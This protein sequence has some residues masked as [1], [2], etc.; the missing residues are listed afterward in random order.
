MSKNDNNSTPLTTLLGDKLLKYDGEEIATASLSLSTKKQ[1]LLYFSAHWCPPCKAFTPIISEAYKGYKEKVGE[2]AEVEI[3]F[4]SRDSDAKTFAQYHKEMSFLAIPFD[5][6]RTGLATKFEIDGIP[7]LIAINQKGEKIFEDVDIRSLI[8]THG[9]ATFP[10]TPERISELKVAENESAV[11]SLRRLYDGEI[12]F[13]IVAKNAAIGRTLKD[14]MLEN[15]YIALVLGDG[16]ASDDRYDNLMEIMEKVNSKAT[17]RCAVI[18]L[19]WST[20]N[21]D[22]DHQKVSEKY[23]FALNEIPT[24]AKE[25]IN[26]IVGNE[27]ADAQT[28][29]ILRRGTGLCMLNGKCEDED[30]PI[31]V[32]VDP[33]L[34]KIQ[35]SSAD[36]FPWDE[37]SMKVYEEKKKLKIDKVRKNLV[38]MKF[39]TDPEGEEGP[40]I[41]QNKDGTALS[42]QLFVGN[43]GECVI[44]LYFSAH[45]C[46]P[47]RAFTPK[48]I[49]CYEEV[50]AAG[51]KFEVIFVSSDSSK[52]EFHSYHNHMK[53]TTGDQFLALDFEKRDLKEMLD[54]AFDVAGVPT[55]VLL[56]PDGTVISEDAVGAVSKGGPDAFPWDEHSVERFLA[57]RLEAALRKEKDEEKKQHDLGATIVKRL[58]GNPCDV[59]HDVDGSMFTFKS[60]CTA[61]APGLFA[62]TGIIYYELEMLNDGEY[63]QFGFALKNGIEQMNKYTGEGVGDD[64]LSWGVDGVRSLKWHDGEE[65]WEGKWTKGNIIG[66]AVNIEKGMMA[67]SKDGDWTED[68]FGVVFQDESIKEGVYPCFTGCMKVRYCFKKDGFKYSL[69]DDSV[70]SA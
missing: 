9:A 41:L 53:T 21:S 28:M 46:P 38:N 4:I 23:S 58:V 55:L 12:P 27:N 52:E 25:A 66:L 51:K 64:S 3:V 60:F 42:E 45:W 33:G 6:D 11:E 20:Y 61:G 26:D 59:E 36:V 63:V 8:T 32:T 39:F 1:I 15:D 31:L 17:N 47:C 49:E 43:E 56:K 5:E 37:A 65:D 62:D 67:M 7:T 70:W 69:P 19:G 57:E 13:P 2:E 35:T 30:T 54:N 24:E 29:I 34:G 10:L 16:D 18:Y 48:L 22:S 68:A 44:G 14:I 50:R 40:I